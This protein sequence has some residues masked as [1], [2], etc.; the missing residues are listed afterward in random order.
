MTRLQAALAKSSLRIICGG[1]ALLWLLAAAGVARSSTYVVYIPL[2]SPIY[3][4]LDTLD[5][6]GMLDTFLQEVKPISRVEAARLTLEAERILD[7]HPEPLADSLVRELRTELR[8]EVGWLEND[9]EDYLP[10]MAQPFERL[11]LQYIYSRGDQRRWQ[12]SDVGTPTEQAIN[13]R[14]VTPLLPNNDGL[15]TAPGSNEVAS[16]YG[17]IG[18]GGFL[19]AYA[20][21]ALAGPLTR[22]VSGVSRLQPV[23][24]AAVADFGNIALSFGMEEMWWGVGHF[25]S[26][27]QSNNASPFPAIRL[28]TVH[29]TQLPGVFR[30]LG[31]FRSQFFFGQMD[32]HR[33]FWHPY[34]F[35]QI[36]SFKPL[37][38]FEFGF[39]HTIMFGGRH[40]DNYGVAGFLGR[41]TG[42]STGSPADGNTHSRGGIYFKSYFP[43][44]RNSEIYLETMGQDNLTN[45]VRGIGRFLPFLSVSYLTGIYIPRLTQDGLTDLRLEVEYTDVNE[46]EHSDSL[47]WAYEGQLMGTSVGPN[48]TRVDLQLGRWLNLHSKLS[49]DAFYTQQAPYHS[50][51]APY[52]QQFYPYPLGNEH[53]G[54]LEVDFLRLPETL[55]LLERPRLAG[56]HFS[57]A[58]EY[59]R[60]LNYQAN[61]NSVRL[62]FSIT[63][64]L[65]PNFPSLK[66]E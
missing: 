64:Y 17:W 12:T 41:A 55:R 39:D 52:P 16:I 40:N 38:T 9:R 61:S 21:G 5:G 66:W 22:S 62:M 37:P 54:G 56:M 11:Q 63:G 45:E 47:Y 49:L 44:L 65:M 43:S 31:Q 27:S 30:Y 10:T 57:A 51:H 23:S 59:V 4:E 32:D 42:F 58:V 35:G 20:D 14:E 26:I 25:N 33:Y 60:D 29:P 1:L 50:D 24:A 53:S 28:Q 8:E 2:D 34:L 3:Q 7:D 18:A 46:E 19:T 15:P 13:A 6:L 48:A 36:F